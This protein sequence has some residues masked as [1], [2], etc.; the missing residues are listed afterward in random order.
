MGKA[1]QSLA[2]FFMPVSALLF[3]TACDPVTIAVVGAGA[4]GTTM[5][6]NDQGISGSVSDTS[7][8]ASINKALLSA[9]SKLFDNLEFCVKHGMV[10]V[11][12]YLPTEEDHVKALDIIN[13]V[14]GYSTKVFDEIKVGE[15]PESSVAQDM[16]I[17]S[18]IK[19]SMTFDGNVSAMNYEVTTVHGV[20]YI[21]GTA[22]SRLERD[23]VINCARTTSSVK[24][25]VAYIEIKKSPNEVS[26]KVGEGGRA[27]GV[28]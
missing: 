16:G 14:K 3:C 27:G 13:S 24:E 19:S 1:I 5:V 2:N 9:D 6:R 7:L 11:I 17:T 26:E 22:M 21:C 23:I 10:V 20:V 25:V 4:A 15:P 28:N 18:R 8:Q 12:G